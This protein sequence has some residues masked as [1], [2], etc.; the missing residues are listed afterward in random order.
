MAGAL[1]QEPRLLIL[2]E[3]TTG[4]D[5]QSRLFLWDMMVDLRERGT[6]LMLTTHDMVEADRLCDRIAIIDH[7]TIIADSTPAQIKA[8]VAGKRVRFTSGRTLTPTDFAALPL[9]HLQIDGDRV[10][11]LSNDP[12]E[13]LRA[14]FSDGVSL[15]DLEVVGADLEEAVIALT[16]RS[17]QKE[18]A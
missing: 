12:E 2:D 1:M 16:A 13:V 11:L 3:P 9:S 5:P 10:T 15:R 7:G 4:L 14:L 17:P 6:T 8:R 18:S